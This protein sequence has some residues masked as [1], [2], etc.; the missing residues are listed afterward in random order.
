MSYFTRRTLFATVT[1]FGGKVNQSKEEIIETICGK[2]QQRLLALT[3]AAMQR[4]DTLQVFHELATSFFSIIDS[5]E[6]QTEIRLSIQLWA[7]ALRTPRIMELHRANVDTVR[8]PFA[9]IIRRAQE[10][11]EI[12]PDLDPD[13]VALVMISFFQGLELHKQVDPGIDVWKYVEVA[14][15][16][17]GG[18]FWQGKRQIDKGAQRPP[19]HKEI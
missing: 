2:S 18:T 13:C 6:A 17:M 10:R 14:L 4:G 9:E 5:P 1:V 15:A 8:R 3:G 12:N 19:P 11:G 7:E 16:L